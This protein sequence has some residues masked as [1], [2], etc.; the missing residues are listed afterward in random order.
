MD[1]DS[2]FEDF[3][4]TLFGTPVEDEIPKKDVKKEENPFEILSMERILEDVYS[5]VQDVKSY[6][7]VSIVAICLKTFF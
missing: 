4:D 1:D 5:K 6:T 7:A 2:S 3:S